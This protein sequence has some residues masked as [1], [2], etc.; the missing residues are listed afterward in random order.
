MD[1]FGGYNKDQID[2]INIIKDLCKSCDIKAYIVGGAVRDSI[3]GKS[4]RDIDICINRD[5]KI[6]I[7]NLSFIKKYEYHSQFQT[8]TIEFNNGIV[9]DLIRCRKETYEKNGSLPIIEPSCIEDDLSRRDFTINA[10]AYDIINN[11]IIDLFNGLLDLRNR[12]LKKIH[13]N[14]YAEDPT[15]IFRA[16]KYSVRY[17]LELYDKNEIIESI[18]IGDI[19]TIS[20][21]RIIKELFLMCGEDNW[22]ENWAL[23]NEL[24]VLKLEAHF[25]GIENCLGSYEDI[26]LR[27][28]NVFYSL[29]DEKYIDIF[30]NNSFLDKD[31]KKTIKYYY[32]N[33]DK[34]VDLLMKAMDNYEICSVLK[35]IDLYALMILCWNTK[36]KYKI[37]NYVFKLKEVKLHINGEYL[38]K[39]GINEGKNV[40]RILKFIMKL[41]LNT[42]I[43]DDKKYLVDNLGEIIKCL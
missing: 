4:T 41:K 1:I 13:S 31:L 32:Y 12:Q 17:G 7:E 20:S 42:G 25:L 33:K 21:D 27:L 38:T 29:K 37:I 43:K 35:N 3:L 2:V 26:N 16:I 36:L 5:P 28:V 39:L 18:N 30:I 40:G 34:I 8:S 10:L 9:I 11:E 14:S 24:G 6:V 15:R 23:C 19:N 22:I